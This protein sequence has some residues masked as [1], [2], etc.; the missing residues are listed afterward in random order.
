MSNV[1]DLLHVRPRLHRRLRPQQE[2]L[3]RAIAA[4]GR[5][6]LDADTEA[7]FTRLVLPQDKINMTFTRRELADPTLQ[8]AA[9]QRLMDALAQRGH[10]GQEAAALCAQ[11]LDMAAA[12]LK[13][14]HPVPAKVELMMARAL[15]L[16]NALPVIELIHR[17]G[18]E[19][20]I[21]YGHSVSDVLDVA[22]WQ[23]VGENNGLQSAGGGQN[24]IYVSCGGHPFLSG[25]ERTYPSDG[26]PALAR[27]MVVAAQETGHNADMIRDGQGKWAGRYS[28]TGWDRAPSAAAGQARAG[29]MAQSQRLLRRCQRL[30]LNLI[31]EWERHLKFFRDNKL[32]NRRRAWAWLKSHLAWRVFALALIASGMGKLRRLQRDPYPA[33]LLR[34]CL[35]DMLF[36]LEPQ[37]EAYRN[38]DPQAEA[39]MLCIEALARIPQQ[40]IKWGHP[41]TACC[42]PGLYALYYGTVVPQCALAAQRL[43]GTGRA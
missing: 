39:A 27:F 36:N 5:M 23:D 12:G 8:K 10:A 25:G 33:A 7:N 37:A 14:R 11:Y 30:G 42:A 9:R 32:Y 22:T 31:A 41:A 2:K 21:S 4:S 16:C 17:E 1:Y 6:R 40:A 19:I 20:F 26:F 29:D 43:A 15:V 3:A 34:Q 13:K 38:P 24:A 35:R 18:A 28:A